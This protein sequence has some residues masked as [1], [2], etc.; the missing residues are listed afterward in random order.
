MSPSGDFRAAIYHLYVRRRDFGLSACMCSSL[1][2]GDAGDHLPPP[3]LLPTAP[4]PGHTPPARTCSSQEQVLR[5]GR[6][7]GIPCLRAPRAKNTRRDFW[8]R[9]ATSSQP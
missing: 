2:D 1:D 8:A 9:R 5:V 7:A 3:L 6:L 4:N